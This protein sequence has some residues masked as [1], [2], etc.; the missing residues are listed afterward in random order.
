MSTALQIMTADEF[1]AWD[2][3]DHSPRWE[4]IDGV[5]VAMAPRSDRHA[6]IHAE[7]ARLIGNHLAAARP[8]CRS[9]IGPGVRPDDTNVRIPDL[10]VSCGPVSTDGSQPREPLLIIEI[11]SPSNVASTRSAVARYMTMP[12][13][14]EILVL[15]SRLGVVQAELWSRAAGGSWSR[16]MYAAGDGVTLSSVGF[17][18][19][20]A[21]FYRTAEA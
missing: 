17:T 8:D 1:L 13:V 11:L 21:A 7:V 16:M 9:M 3:P 18:A 14:R 15:D 12:G 20:L 2:P 5:P 19:P 4:L 10:T 6:A